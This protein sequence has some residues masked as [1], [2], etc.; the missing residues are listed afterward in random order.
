METKLV[1]VPSGH[2]SCELE[3]RGIPPETPV[4]DGH[5]GLY[6]FTKSDG[7]IHRTPPKDD[8]MMMVKKPWMWILPKAH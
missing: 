3:S 4:V 6:S 8:G 7:K 5:M 1:T 2:A